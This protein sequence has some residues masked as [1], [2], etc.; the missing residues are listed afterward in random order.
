MTRGN[1]IRKQVDEAVGRF[2]SSP[3]RWARFIGSGHR[4]T[5]QG[6]SG[7]S[8]IEVA[9]SLSVL[10]TFLFCFMELS[11]VFYSYSM[12]SECAR[13]GT[14]YAMYRGATCMTSPG[15]TSCTATAA[16]IQNYVSGLGWP[17]IGGGTFTPVATFPDGNEA[18]GSRVQVKVTYVFPISMPFVPKNS[19]T[20][21]STSVVK[22]VQ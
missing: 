22:I 17:N 6:E 5:I 3:R 18:A 7:Q 10:F 9:F 16:Q 2:A 21:A 8:I 4:C 1:S 19:I 13:E 15:N 14:R 11:L 20:M 12:I